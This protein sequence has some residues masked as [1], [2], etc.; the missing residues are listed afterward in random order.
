M[1]FV[2]E[3]ENRR[4]NCLLF[5][6]VETLVGDA[7]IR[8]VKESSPGILDSFI[9]FKRLKGV[10]GSNFLNIEK[11]ILDSFS[12]DSLECLNSQIEKKDV[13]CLLFVL[14]FSMLSILYLLALIVL[15]SNSA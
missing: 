2:C 9:N 4:Y 11:G 5:F 15:D 7:Y 10:S 1:L 6:A 13:R 3:F 8:R 12:I 14:S